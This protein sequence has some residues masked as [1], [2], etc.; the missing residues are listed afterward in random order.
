MNIIFEIDMFKPRLGHP[1]RTFAHSSPN[2]HRN[3]LDTVGTH[4]QR[5]SFSKNCE[6]DCVRVVFLPAVRTLVRPG[7][8]HA[9]VASYGVH[10]D[11][12]H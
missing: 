10:P 9:S 5:I 11:D 3:A 6:I 2:C 12:L 7:L 8:R 4:N 1:S